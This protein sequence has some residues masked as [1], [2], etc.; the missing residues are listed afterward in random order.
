MIAIALFIHFTRTQTLQDLQATL[1]SIMSGGL[2]GLFLL[3]LL[4]RRVDGRSALQA[5]MTTL[6]GVCIWLFIDSQLGAELFP[7]FVALLP[8]KFWVIVLANTF[9]FVLGVLLSYGARRKSDRNL[10]DLTVWTRRSD[11]VGA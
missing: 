9:L 8:D 2:L 5:T 3:G 7:S 4:T 10:T 11:E 6:V 1:I